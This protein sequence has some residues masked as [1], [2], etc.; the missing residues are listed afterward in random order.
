MGRVSL[1]RYIVVSGGS[2]CS[3]SPQEAESRQPEL[4]ESQLTDSSHTRGQE[5]RRPHLSP[6]LPRILLLRVTSQ[7]DRCGGTRTHSYRRVAAGI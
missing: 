3:A 4:E 2:C 5:P 6:G 1:T 7:R